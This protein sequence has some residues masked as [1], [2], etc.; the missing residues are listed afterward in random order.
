M[1][2]VVKMKIIVIIITTIIVSFK[3]FYTPSYF[4]VVVNTVVTFGTSMSPSLVFTSS[5]GNECYKFSRIT[6]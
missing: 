2:L 3:R 6:N 1:Q 5:E 4:F